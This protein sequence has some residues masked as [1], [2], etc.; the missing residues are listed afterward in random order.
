MFLKNIR[1]NNGILIRF[2]DIAP[3]MNWELMDMCQ[4][5]LND[6]KIKPVLGV[7]PKN[8]DS[9]LLQ[10]PAR[11]DFWKIVKKWEAYGWKIAMHGYNHVYDTETKKKDYF[12]YGG[13][14]EFFGH[15]IEIQEKKLKAGLNIF[16]ENDIKIDTFFAPN[17]TYDLN[18]FNALKAVG[19]YQVIDGYGLLPYTKNKIKFV[20]QLFYKLYTLPFGIQTTQIHL[21]YWSENDFRVFETFIKKNHQRIISVDEAFNDSFDGLSF[22]AVNLFL[23]NILILKRLLF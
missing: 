2:D 15:P 19:I 21:N 23:K 11:K 3:N 8:E 17:H 13:K 7:I 22:K 6:F 1:S 14:S 5:L 10:Y 12:N 16:K 9:N 18:T 20:P 4:K